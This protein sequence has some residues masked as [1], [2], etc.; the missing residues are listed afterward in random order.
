MARNGPKEVVSSTVYGVVI[1]VELLR[2]FMRA[3]YKFASSLKPRTLRKPGCPPPLLLSSLNFRDV[4]SGFKY[5]QLWVGTFFYG[6][7][8]VLFCICMYILLRR[9]WNLG[10]GV[11]LCTAIALFGLSTA[12]VVINLVLGAVDLREITIDFRPLQTTTI[13][14]YGINNFIADGLVIYRCYCIWNNSARVV[15]VPVILLIITTVFGVIPALPSNPLFIFSLA[16]NILVTALTVGRIWW[17]ARK[18]RAYLQADAQRRYSSSA[19]ILIES[20]ALY[21]ATVLAYLIMT[22]IP[23]A[24]ILLQLVFQMLTQIMGIAPTLIIVRVG[25]GIS[26]FASEAEKAT[27]KSG[28]TSKQNVRLAASWDAEKGG[29]SDS[30]T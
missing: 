7:Y 26:V 23:S 2:V 16:T 9:P 12:Q 3:K 24:R 11:L 6:I 19:A 18:G 8:F 5:A 25:M 14:L 13:V 1:V 15:V 29:L 27:E 22:T 4:P 21:S 28:G 17:I 10:T 30:S 20:G